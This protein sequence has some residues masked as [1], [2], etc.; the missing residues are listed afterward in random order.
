MSDQ[1]YDKLPMNV[2]KYKKLLR[3]NNPELFVNTGVKHQVITDPEYQKNL[4]DDLNIGDR[5]ELVKD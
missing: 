3:Q 5:L 2:R 1:D 4:V